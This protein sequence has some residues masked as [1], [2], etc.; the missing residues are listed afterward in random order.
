MKEF[1]DQMSHDT[2]VIGKGEFA[3]AN[4]IDQQ[5]TFVAGTSDMGIGFQTAR[6]GAARPFHRSQNFGLYL[7][8]KFRLRAGLTAF[9]H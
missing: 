9:P 6:A 4:E 7:E 8:N 1:Y 2:P 3:F 5:L